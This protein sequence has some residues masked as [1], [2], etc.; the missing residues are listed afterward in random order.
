MNQT[1]AQDGNDMSGILGI[2]NDSNTDLCSN[3]TSFNDTLR[4]LSL[5]ITTILVLGTVVG[6]VMIM[7][8][9]FVDATLK[10]SVFI[11]IQSLSGITILST[12]DIIAR[13]DFYT[14]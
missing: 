14:H 12:L 7:I 13:V 3:K 1:A 6:N 5:V 10:S 2:S 8:I 11:A 4:L 9:I